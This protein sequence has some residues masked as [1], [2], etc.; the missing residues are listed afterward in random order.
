M[1]IILKKSVLLSIVECFSLISGPTA[2][3]FAM[4]ALILTGRAISPPTAFTVLAF[5]S[6]LRSSVSVVLAAVFEI[7]VSLKRIQ[8]FLLLDNMPLNPLE[9]SQT[10]LGQD[11]IL[12]R[13][14]AYPKVSVREAVTM[15][16]VLP[17]SII[18]G[19]HE[20]AKQYEF[21][22]KTALAVSNLSCKL[23]ES[24][25]KYLLQDVSF[26]ASEKSLTVITG[27]V[28]SGKSTLLAAIAGE[29]IQSSGNIVCSGK[30]AYVSQ[31]AWVFSGTLRENVL[32]GE[33]YDEKK[34][35]D[36]I[37]ACALTEDINRSPNGDLS[38][39]GER[40]VVLS[41]G[42]RARVNLARAVYADADVYLLDDPLSAVDAKVSEHIFDQ[43]ICRLLQEKIKILVTY[44]EKHMKVAD[45]VV[46]LHE[47]SVLGKGSLDELQDNRNFLHTIID[48]SQP[49][50]K[51]RKNPTTGDENVKL[52][53]FFE[54][55]SGGSDEH[56]EIA[57]EEKA[58]GKISSTLYW[59]YFR[60]GTHPVAM[61]L[62]VVL[63]LAAQGELKLVHTCD[64]IQ[65]PMQMQLQTTF[66]R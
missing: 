64:A 10:S 43:C 44:A 6:V 35:A 56:L 60:A 21:L 3:F 29:V 36:V 38:M 5:M 25:Q 12:K 4:F 11:H 41:G 42:Q 24:N 9:Y 54:P 46:V 30:I 2:T 62:L 31:T 58:T 19:L 47:G 28:G 15:D 40:G 52:H 61:I 8:T 37:E 45:Q 18:H 13:P 51:E 7:F 57:E 55:F 33:P 14:K 17:S 32:F 20:D 50:S 66:T 48:S 22:S 53:S 1:W 63:F 16:A 39:V 65:T 49:Y 27:Q 23:D 34:Y 26:E 59:D